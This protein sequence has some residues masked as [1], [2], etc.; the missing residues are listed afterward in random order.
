V[1][2]AR[3]RGIDV[4]CETCPH[5]LVFADE[6]LEALGAVGK[7]APPLRPRAEVEA[8]RAEL[9]SVDLLASDHSP[10]PASMKRGDDFSALWGGISGCQSLLPNVLTEDLPVEL[11]TSRPAAR[12]RLPGKGL[13]E[14]GYDAD[15]VL[16]EPATEWELGLDDLR[17]RHKHS[18][19]VG[20]RFRGRVVRTLVRGGARKGRLVKPS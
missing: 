12:F 1:A 7:C 18:P 20:R 6:D 9:G 13:L 11:V 3:A 4:T 5:Y 14:V 2:E 19:Y 16:V 17:Y 8:L 10:S 15:L